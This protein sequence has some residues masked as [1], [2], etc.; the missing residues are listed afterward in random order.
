MHS[1]KYVIGMGRVLTLGVRI[2][3]WGIMLPPKA[4][5]ETGEIIRSRGRSERCQCELE[6]LPKN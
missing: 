4:S 5:D 1:N 6:K 3:T 2:M